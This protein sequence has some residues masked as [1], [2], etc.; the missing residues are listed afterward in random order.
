MSRY[1][2]IDTRIHGDEKFRNLSRPKPCGQVL[3]YYLLAPREANNI[4]GLFSAGEAGLAEYLGWP[5]KS[6][7]TSWGEIAQQRMAIADWKAGVVFLFNGIK[8][9]EPSNPN[10]ITSWKDPWD[11]IP[12]CPVKWAAYLTLRV[13]IQ[14]RFSQQRQE[15]FLKAFDLAVPEPPRQSATASVIQLLPEW[16]S[17]RFAKQLPEWLPGPLRKG[18]QERFGESVTVTGT[19][20]GSGTGTVPVPLLSS[21]P[22]DL[23]VREEAPPNGDRPILFKSLW[24][25]VLG[26]IRTYLGDQVFEQQGFDSSRIVELSPEFVT[27][28]VPE[29]LLELQGGQDH[30]ARRMHAMIAQANTG[31]MRGRGLKLISIEKLVQQEFG[32]S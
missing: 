11:N 28:A 20:T 4:P 21:N 3:W 6:F 29:Q 15:G 10:Q 17:I 16:L 24:A 9:D 1:R 7:R 31:L 5:I 23:T 18:F 14:V 32:N 26:K 22:E 8:Y 27:I 25:P 12:E 19:D 2:K 13:Y 30:A